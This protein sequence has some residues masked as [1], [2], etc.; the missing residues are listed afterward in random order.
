MSVSAAA[1]SAAP[2]VR[3]WR[4]RIATNVLGDVA[5]PPEVSSVDRS[6]CPEYGDAYF[7]TFVKDPDGYRLEAKSSF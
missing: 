5:V 6:R 1:K 7:A 2:P 4:L 3:N